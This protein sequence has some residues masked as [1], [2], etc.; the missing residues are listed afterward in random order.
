MESAVALIRE[1]AKQDPSGQSRIV[2]FP[3][4]DIVGKRVSRSVAA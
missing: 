4:V 2:V 3:M 1:T